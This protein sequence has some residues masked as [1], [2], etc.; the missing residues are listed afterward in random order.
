MKEMIHVM[1]QDVP[2]KYESVMLSFIESAKAG[3]IDKLISLTSKV[4][5]EKIGLENLKRHYQKDT[6]PALKACNAILE[7]GEIIHITKQQS[8]TGS[9]WLYRKVCTYGENKKIQVQFVI[10]NENGQIV[11]TSFGLG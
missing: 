4:T 10:L 2:E 11:L 7:G 1:E 9:G 3:D 6:I 8:G 5:I